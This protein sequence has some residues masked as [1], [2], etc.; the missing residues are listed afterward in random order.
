MKKRERAYRVFIR[1]VFAVR[2]AARLYEQILRKIEANNM[3]IF[4]KIV[5]TSTLEKLILTLKEMV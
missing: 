5:G 4:S 2:V 3:D 1:I